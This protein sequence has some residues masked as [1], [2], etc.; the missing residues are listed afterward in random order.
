[1]A[2][3]KRPTFDAND[4]QITYVDYTTTNE[5]AYQAR[6]KRKALASNFYPYTYAFVIGTTEPA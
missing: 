6:R 1:M 2:V 5:T 3:I 4:L